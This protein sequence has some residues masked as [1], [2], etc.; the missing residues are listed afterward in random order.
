MR[1]TLLTIVA[2][3]SLMSCVTS[4]DL[5]SA[6]PTTKQVTNT[7]NK[8][9]NYVEANEW[10]VNSFTNAESVIQFTDKAAGIVKGKYLLKDGVASSTYS[11]GYASIYATITVRVKDNAA[12]LEIEPLSNF[13]SMKSMGVEYGFTKENFQLTVRALETSFTEAMTES[14]NNDW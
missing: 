14:S 10:M 9:S 8:D 12:K 11:T 1:K 7:L 4:K 6:E 5:G 13:Y 2:V 3:I